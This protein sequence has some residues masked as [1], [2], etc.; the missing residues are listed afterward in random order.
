M[1]QGKV[2]Q[3]T[4]IIHLPLHFLYGGNHIK[5]SVIQ[6]ARYSVDLAQLQATMK[7]HIAII[8]FTASLAYAGLYHQAPVYVVHQDPAV[9]SADTYGSGHSD[10]GH[11]NSGY[12]AHGYGAFR[13]KAAH[14]AYAHGD[15]GVDADSAYR[16]LKAQGAVGAAH[17]NFKDKG[18]YARNRGFGY[19][20]AYAY[21]KQ[22]AAHDIGAKS[23]AYGQKFGL[24]DVYG[25]SNLDAHNKYAHGAHGAHDRYGAAGYGRYGQLNTGYGNTG[26]AHGAKSYALQPAAAY[27]VAH[28]A[29]AK[30]Y[31][32]PY[33]KITYH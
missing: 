2:N 5:G 25:H 28:P 24:S 17:S 8:L 12:G 6:Q 21:D 11:L 16:N 14:G 20:K 18:L 15:A 10:Y 27:V 31:S 4:S 1:P 23:G 9:S 26:Y 19:E 13:D 7:I 29:P 32:S 30:S 33:T 3:F 22:L